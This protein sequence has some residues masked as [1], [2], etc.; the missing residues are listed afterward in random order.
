MFKNSSSYKLRELSSLAIGV[1]HFRGMENGILSLLVKK[2]DN[3]N[4]Y[5]VIPLAIYQSHCRPYVLQTTTKCLFGW[6]LILIH[7]IKNTFILHQALFHLV[8]VFLVY[9]VVLQNTHGRMEPSDN[10]IF[11]EAFKE[12]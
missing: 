1:N 8:F 10:A 9:T 4:R 5:L 12:F 6:S 7:R 3:I 11:L 2:K